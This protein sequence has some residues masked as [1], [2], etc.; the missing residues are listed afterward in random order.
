[1]ANCF[2]KCCRVLKHLPVRLICVLVI[3]LHFSIVDYYLVEHK[4]TTWLGFLAAD[5]I[6]LCLFVAS[7]ILSY[8]R[9]KSSNTDTKMEKMGIWMG[10]ASW[11]LYS[12]IV[13][14]KSGII[15]IDFADDL[16]ENDFFGPNTLKTA[17][18]LAGVIF[19][20]HLSSLHDAKPGSERR[21]YIEELSGTVI[22]DI[23]DCVDSME[24]LFIKE[25]REDFPPGLVEA[26]VAVAC[27]N[28]VLPTVPLLTLSHTKFGYA[29][30]PRRLIMVHKIILAY[31]VNLPLLVMRMI[32]WH[33]LNH[34]VSIFSLKNVIVIAMISYD[35]YEHHEADMDNS[36]EKNNSNK[37]ENGKES[38]PA[39]AYG[40]EDRYDYK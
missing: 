5:V 24:P 9:L 4:D 28:F 32:L 16:D 13:A 3:I 12:V 31:I 20:L 6:T 15:F 1:M 37:G 38:L 33:G 22:F 30:L 10:L 18:A 34:G 39:D 25:D 35:F 36:M 2:I 8:N 14:T 23:L 26:I 17:L 29:K 27:L 19:L 21:A 7:F 40:L 11:F